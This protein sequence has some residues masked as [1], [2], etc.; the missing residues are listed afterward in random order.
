VVARKPNE[1]QADGRTAWSR[2]KAELRD[3]PVYVA[4]YKFAKEVLGEIIRQIPVLG[5]LIMGGLAAAESLAGEPAEP[6]PRATATVQALV[7]T[8]RRELDFREEQLAVKDAQIRSLTQAVQDL[9]KRAGS[10][11][12]PPEITAAETD[13]ELGDPTRARTFYAA[14]WQSEATRGK[15]ANRKAAQAGRYVAALDALSDS[16]SALLASQSAT[17]LD[18]DDPEGWLLHASLLQRTGQSNPAREA[19]QRALDLAD[20]RGDPSFILIAHGGLGDVAVSQ[21]N[22]AQAALHFDQ[23]LAITKRLSEARPKDSGWQRDLSVSYDRIGDVRVAQGDRAGALEAFEQGRAIRDK[24]AARDPAN[25][26]WQRDLSVSLNKIGDVR[27]AQGDRAGALEAFEQGRAIADK[28]AARDPANAE[29]Q[30]DLIVS[31]V[32]LAGVAESQ[33]G[34]TSEAAKHYRAALDIAVAL[35]D[36]GRL[37]PVDGWMVG[38]LEARLARVSAQAGSQ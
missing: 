7:A 25:A 24:L 23:T 28:L 16:A 30:R 37:A 17:E 6:D 14:L 8:H 35:R 12:A 27:V 33:A 26:E 2:L 3:E 31:N 19:Y 5:P 4:A 15:A 22:L 1:A 34:K 18:P 21:G 36:S 20:P 9:A 38:D 32:K 10:P 29:W 13:L 11:D